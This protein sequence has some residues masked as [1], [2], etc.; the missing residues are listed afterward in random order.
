MKLFMEMVH[1]LSLNPEEIFSFIK[2]NFS[3]GRV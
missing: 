3:I 2:A 1:K